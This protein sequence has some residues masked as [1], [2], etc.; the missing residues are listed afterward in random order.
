MEKKT[1][2]KNLPKNQ[3]RKTNR[4]LIC[5]LYSTKLKMIEVNI[6]TALIV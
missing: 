3:S 4:V 2:L 1:E 6:I 5:I